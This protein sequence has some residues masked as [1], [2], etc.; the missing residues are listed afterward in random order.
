[1]QDGLI[2]C[3]DG[4]TLENSNGSL[5]E[6]LQSNDVVIDDHLLV[7]VGVHTLTKSGYQS[8][9]TQAASGRQGAE[10]ESIFTD[11]VSA[12]LKTK[13]LVVHCE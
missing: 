2:Q 3:T 9:F 11:R 13:E 7:H 1:M 8:V 6:T 4:E 10:M 12:L 5:N